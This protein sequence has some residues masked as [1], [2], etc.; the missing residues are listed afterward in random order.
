LSWLQSSRLPSAIKRGS[1]AA[2]VEAGCAWAVCYALIKTRLFEPKAVPR[3][4][5]L[6]LSLFF[7]LS[8]LASHI[9]EEWSAGEA[10]HVGRLVLPSIFLVVTAVENRFF[11]RE[12]PDHDSGQWLV[13]VVCVALTTAQVFVM[14][15]Q[16]TATGDA[17]ILQL[18]VAACAVQACTTGMSFLL[19]LR[20]VRPPSSCPT[21][22]PRSVY[23]PCRMQDS[24]RQLRRDTQGV[25]LKPCFQ[26]GTRA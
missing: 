20:G 23:P 8:V 5:L 13:L 1:L 10:E 22:S 14:S 16:P 11:H 3:Q 18:V 12:H 6:V 4:Q 17:K 15:S 24:L 19:W 9:A 2:L 7:G 21:D 25:D 26:R